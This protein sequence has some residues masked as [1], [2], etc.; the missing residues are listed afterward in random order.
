MDSAW[1]RRRRSAITAHHSFLISPHSRLR[2]LP[3]LCVA[4][5]S[6]SCGPDGQMPWSRSAHDSHQH[7]T[8]PGPLAGAMPPF[9]VHDANAQ[10]A[11]ADP[12]SSGVDARV[13]SFVGRFPADDRDRQGRATPSQSPDPTDQAATAKPPAGPATK[14]PKARTTAMARAASGPPTP[15]TTTRSPGV[16]AMKSVD[17]LGAPAD[18]SGGGSDIQASPQPQPSI[19]LAPLPEPVGP[20][21]ELIDVRPAGITAAAPDA[22]NAASPA[23][24]PV[25]PTGAT[26]GNDLAGMLAELE[27][28]VKAHP[29]QLDNQFKLRLLYLATD[30]D[31]KAAGPIA[32]GDP[33]QAHLATA[34]FGLLTSAKA[35][36]RRPTSSPSPALLAAEEVRRILGQQSPVIIPKLALVTRVSSFGDYAPVSPAKFPAGQGV[37]VFLYTEVANFRS[38]PTPDGRLRTLLAETVEIFDSTGKVI[39][40]QTAD[41]IEDKV[42]SPR[43]DFFIPIEVRLP[44]TTP[45]GE[46]VLKAG[47]EDKLG[48]TT[49]QQRMTFTIE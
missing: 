8:T 11:P 47:I 42:L 34:L 43:R 16:Q 18:E 31:D 6:A 36:L 7:N 22:D 44:A 30:Q 41:N 39:W 19:A 10:K 49:D 17:T 24:R 33:L 26:R 9:S 1:M 13:Q 35:A 2:L 48:A 4:L 3:L 20:R 37:H 21:A 14:T 46:Y 40:K 45:P 27:E 29:E 32:A 15:G 28:A 38:E 23:N 12:E 25:Q 5:M